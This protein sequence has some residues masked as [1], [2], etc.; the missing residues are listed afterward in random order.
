MSGWSIHIEAV[1]TEPAD[2]DAG[3]DELLDLL[4]VRGGS[5]TSTIDGTRYGATFSMNFPA[6][7]EAVEGVELEEPFTETA[8]AVAHWACEYFRTAS[9]LAGLPAWPI[10]RCE[11]LTDEELD[12]ELATPNFPELVGVAELADILG[13]SRPRASQIQTSA[14]FPDPVAVLRAGPVWTRPSINHFLEHWERRGGRPKKDVTGP[15]SRAATRTRRA[16]P[17]L[18]P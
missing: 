1:G 4:A 18:A 7:I 17:S 10:V 11:V 12:R 6:D 3:A 8:A 14:A 2:L 5:V 9:K 16:K 13:V 15:N